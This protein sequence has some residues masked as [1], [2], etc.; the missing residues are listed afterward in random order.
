MIELKKVILRALARYSAPSKGKELLAQCTTL[1]V[2]MMYSII[3]RAL[4][5]KADA[6]S[7]RYSCCMLIPKA[8]PWSERVLVF[9]TVIYP[10]VSGKEDNI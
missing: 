9:Q 8:M 1:G 4:G 6:L 5:A 3:V 10:M 2:I 7:E